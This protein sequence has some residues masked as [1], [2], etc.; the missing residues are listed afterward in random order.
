MCLLLFYFNISMEKRWSDNIQ[1]SSFSKNEEN[2]GKHAQNVH[3]I[4]IMLIL[5]Y[6]VQCLGSKNTVGTVLKN[7]YILN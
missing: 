5:G 1:A 7:Y 2:T 4:T 3:K 6:T